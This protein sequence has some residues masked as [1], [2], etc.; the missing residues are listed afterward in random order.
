MFRRDED[1]I[2]KLKQENASQKEY[3]EELQDLKNHYKNTAEEQRGTI[4]EQNDRIEKITNLVEG[5][6]YG[7]EKAILGKIKEVIR[8]QTK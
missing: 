2:K 3:I 5:N 6:T 1:E 4:D 7:N 8:R